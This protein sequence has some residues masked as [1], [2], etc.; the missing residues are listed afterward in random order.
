MTAVSDLG[1]GALMA[2]NATLSLDHDICRLSASLGER[3]QR[4]K[5]LAPRI[6]TTAVQTS[7]L[8]LTWSQ[9]IQRILVAFFLFGLL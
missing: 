5:R 2:P 6:E 4:L 7:P 3:I 1:P 9:A 8:T